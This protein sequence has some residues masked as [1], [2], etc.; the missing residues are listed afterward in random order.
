MMTEYEARKLTES[1]HK[2]LNG[3]PSPVRQCVAGLLTLIAI[4]LLGN[5]FPPTM[6]GALN[7]AD[8]T[9]SAPKAVTRVEVDSRVGV[10]TQSPQYARTDL[11]PAVNAAEAGAK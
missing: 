5:L 2:E 8:A 10:E 3:E 9:A 11:L 6:G 7:A 1:M 4:L